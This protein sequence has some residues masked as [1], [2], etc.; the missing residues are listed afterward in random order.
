MQPLYKIQSWSRYI[1]ARV[2]IYHHVQD[3]VRENYILLLPTGNAKASVPL[4][5]CNNFF[6]FFRLYLLYIY[7]F[8]DEINNVRMPKFYFRAIYFLTICVSNM[9]MKWAL[10]I[11]R[12]T[13]FYLSYVEQ[14]LGRK[15]FQKR[16]T[17]SFLN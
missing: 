8:I 13:A 7:L 4:L 10:L 2:Q 5:L 1:L 12:E 3:P 16:K 17:I 6:F 14:A 15:L 11:I 9:Q